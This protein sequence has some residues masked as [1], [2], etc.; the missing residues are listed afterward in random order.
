MLKA[1][2]DLLQAIRYI[3]G[4][5]VV[6][7]TLDQGLL[8][9]SEAKTCHSVPFDNATSIGNDVWMWMFRKELADF[10][11]PKKK[12]TEACFVSGVVGGQIRGFHVAI[13]WFLNGGHGKPGGDQRA[14]VLCGNRRRVYVKL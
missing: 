5:I 8:V 1:F 3:K 7:D 6:I 10:S 2:L 12:S 11:F 9:L 13:L 4:S 14:I